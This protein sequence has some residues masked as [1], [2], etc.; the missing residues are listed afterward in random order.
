MALQEFSHLLLP[1]IQLRSDQ[2]WWQTLNWHLRLSLQLQ[3]RLANECLDWP[4]HPPPPPSYWLMKA[5]IAAFSPLSDDSPTVE[6]LPDWDLVMF[7][8]VNWCWSLQL[9]VCRDCDTLIAGNNLLHWVS[10]CPRHL[11]L[12]EKPLLHCNCNYRLSDLLFTEIGEL[13]LKLDIYP[14]GPRPISP[15]LSIQPNTIVRKPLS[16]WSFIRNIELFLCS[17]LFVT[18]E[19]R[20]SC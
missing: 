4:D 5:V 3:S 20:T 19:L 12:I 16:L 18:R 15:S 14:A 11:T 6:G 7:F 2:R 17:G 10:L 8:I 13:F 9:S 1:Q